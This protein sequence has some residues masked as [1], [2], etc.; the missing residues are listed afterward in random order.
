MVEPPYRGHVRPG[1]LAHKGNILLD[2][3]DLQL[4][5]KKTL[6]VAFRMPVGEVEG[7]KVSTSE[8]VPSIRASIY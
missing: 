3:E 5:H 4:Y 8:A 2:T 7:D 6:H 1:L